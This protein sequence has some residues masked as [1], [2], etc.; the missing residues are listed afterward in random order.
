M[1]H[2]R[3]LV[4]MPGLLGALFSKRAQRGSW[5]A[6]WLAG[7]RRSGLGSGRWSHPTPE[8]DICYLLLLLLLS[9]TPHRKG[10]AQAASVKERFVRA[11][12]K[13]S[14]L[15]TP[16]FLYNCALCSPV[17]FPALFDPMDRRQAVSIIQTAAIM[18][19]DPSESYPPVLGYFEWSLAGSTV[20]LTLIVIFI[21][22]HRNR[23]VKRGPSELN[24]RQ[25]RRAEGTQPGREE[26]T[27]VETS[28]THACCPEVLAGAPKETSALPDSAN[29]TGDVFFCPIS[30]NRHDCGRMNLATTGNDAFDSSKEILDGMWLGVSVASQNITNGRVMACGHRYV[31][32]KHDGRIW[33]MI[34]RC[35]IRSNNLQLD[36]SDFQ[37]QDYYEVCNPLTDHREQGMCTMGISAVITQDEVVVG[38]P[39]S[40]DWQ[41]NAHIIWRSPTDEYTTAESKFGNLDRRNIYMGYSVA[42]EKGVL[43]LTKET[44]LTGAPRDG[45]QAI[46][47]T[48][49]VMLTLV[50]VVDKRPLSPPKLILYG[51][52][53]GSYF[54][55]SIAVIDL[56]NDGWKDVIV[57]APFYFNR[58]K[59]EGG[60]VYIYMNENGSFRDK[61]DIAL[62]GREGSAFGMSVAGIGD[63]N[64]DG[65]QDF[66]VG[67]PYHE[68]GSV[69]IWMGNETGIS[70]TPSQEIKGRDITGSGFH[71][72]GYSVS[73]GMDIDDNKYP[74]VV[75][76]S[77]DDRIAVLRARPVIHLQSEF[78]VTPDI[79]D[80]EN[81][82]DCV[83]ARVCLSYL[84]STGESGK[85]N[86]TVEFTLT[87][88]RTR[89]SPRLVFLENNANSI[90]GSF[91]MPS[92]K[93]RPFTLKLKKPIRDK[94]EPVH[95][96]LNMSLYEPKPKVRGMQ[97]LDAYPVLSEGKAIIKKH[98]IH[99]QKACGTDNKCNSNL[100]MTAQFASFTN[101]QPLIFEEGHQIFKYNSSVKKLMLHIDITNL[102]SDGHPAEDAHNTVLNITVPPALQFSSV[103]PKNLVCSGSGPG[104]LCEFGSPIGTNQEIRVEIA[105]ET[106]GINLDTREIRAEIQMSTLSEQSPITPIALT[107]LV[108]YLLQPVFAIL[109]RESTTFFSGK[110]MG[111]SAMESTSDVGSPVR[112]TFEVKLVG[113]PLGSLGTL[114][115]AFDW[116]F[117]VANGKWLLYLTKITTTGTSGPCVPP[118]KGVVN[119]LRLLLAEELRR[120][121]ELGSPVAEEGFQAEQALSQAPLKAIRTRKKLISLSCDRGARC[122]TFTCPLKN[123]NVSATVTIYARLW[124]STMLEDY[125]DA[126]RVKVTS[127]ATLRLQTSKATVIMKPETQSFTLNIDADQDE[128]APSEAPVWIIVVS[129]LAGILL[130]ALIIILLWK[131]GFFKRAST[132]ELY[133]AKAHKAEMRTQP[134]END[135]LTEDI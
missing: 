20:A 50:T 32:K 56:N 92:Q 26:R 60:A 129:V 62:R 45:P 85:R 73:G 2:Q 24:E 51:E 103:K 12:P 82:V 27:R 70:S 94:V 71:T 132:R 110:V 7:W 54:G 13:P 131:C 111:E 104:F 52:Q 21:V 53:V 36:P 96:Y 31:Q 89:H 127:Q 84:L 41:G 58:M 1:Y 95:F 22:D 102:E 97:N 118:E 61:Y 30:M 47:A 120:K 43:S 124:N 116:P 66:A 4:P 87:A 67:A 101:D 35:Y 18:R 39:G 126:Y 8:A 125:T 11:F 29:Q 105:F 133:E 5:L 40:F 80:S 86:I 128:E 130:L 72:F 81:C 42:K 99:F 113:R 123:M 88:D 134:S 75:V 19:I 14:N 106:S 79:V 90:T 37:W 64:Q 76:G 9:H 25:L 63:I 119:P 69:F 23:I 115:I 122:R 98:E 121:R 65:F 83:E 117:E 16:H 15:H 108:E 109:P 17:V 10:L 49:S 114:Q 100:K 6:G 135:R 33:S 57:G 93:C 74:D 44:L 112:F 68:G 78:S 38:S 48:G 34:G 107:L 46:L 77:L 91:Y 3:L 59:E 28:S 55:N